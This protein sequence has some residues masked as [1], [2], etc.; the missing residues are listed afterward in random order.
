MPDWVIHHL[1]WW[2]SPAMSQ[3]LPLK[4]RDTN[5][6][7]FT[8]ASTHGWGGSTGQP[9]YQWPVVQRSTSE[10]HQYFGNIS[11]LLCRLWFSQQVAWMGG[12]LMCDNATVVSYIKQEGGTKSFRLTIRLLKFCDHKGIVIVPV[13]LPGHCNIQVESLS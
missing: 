8:D 12:L 3:G 10:P 5:F 2:A 9:Q 13:H 11:H 4:I 6:T 7:L 1:A